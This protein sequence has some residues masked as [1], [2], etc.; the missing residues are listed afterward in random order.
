MSKKISRILLVLCI[1]LVSAVA[2]N[3]EAATDSCLI[4]VTPPTNYGI[5]ITTPSATNGID[6]GSIALQ[7]VEYNTLVTTVTNSGSVVSDWKIKLE[8]LDTWMVDDSNV[9][10]GA[11][12]DNTNVGVD[13]VTICAVLA[14]TSVAV[15]SDD[16]YFDAADLLKTTLQNMASS[17]YAYDTAD[18]NNVGAGTAYRLHT[19]IKGP[20]NTTVTSEQQFR[21]TVE[22]Y[23]SDEF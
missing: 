21:I 16:T 2:M 8:S 5:T 22:T 9:A 18:G 14:E 19:R 3:V 11:D 12:G 1:A 13:T 20:S 17:S 7:D 15:P 23:A 4:S 6:F 10:M